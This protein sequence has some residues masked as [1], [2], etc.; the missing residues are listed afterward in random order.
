MQF[1]TPPDGYDEVFTVGDRW[2]SRTANVANTT[3]SEVI[4]VLYDDNGDR[5]ADLVLTVNRGARDADMY[6]NAAYRPGRVYG[7]RR[8][9]MSRKWEPKPF[10]PWVR[11]TVYLAKGR[12]YASGPLGLRLLC[13]LVFDNGD[14]VLVDTGTQGSATLP[15]RDRDAYNES[16]PV[17]DDPWEE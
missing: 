11:G 6:G 9:E 12:G 17:G 8:Y 2:R 14:A 15:A 16:G 7:R 10:L 13:I 5:D 1:Q 3:Y 4:G